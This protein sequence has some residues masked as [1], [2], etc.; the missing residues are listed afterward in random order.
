VTL[1]DPGSSEQ[2]QPPRPSSDP[3]AD[4]DAVQPDPVEQRSPVG[5]VAERAPVRDVGLRDG[6]RF[7]LWVFAAVWICWSVLGVIGVLI[8][9][10]RNPVSVPGLATSPLTTGWHNALTAGQRED[11]LWFQR[12][13]SHGYRS[14]DAS[15]AFFPL[16]PLTIRVVSMVPGVG[17][18]VAAALVAQASF[19]GALVVLYSLTA[20][21]LGV[22]VARRATV[23]LAVFPTAF[24]FLAA[25]SESLFL[26]L[27]LLAF[28]YARAGRWW[29]AVVPAVLVGLTRSVGVMVAAALL[30]EAVLQWRRSRRGL[31]PALAAAAAPL[32]GLGLY[33]TFWA[34][35]GDV[36]APV[37]AQD[38]WQRQVT[39]MPLTLL[40]AVQAAWR[41][42]SYWLIDLLVVGIIIGAVVG[43]LRLLPA[44]Y[45]T[46]AIGSLLLPLSE[47]FPPRPLMSMPR[48]VSVVFP[49]FWVIAVAVNRR[50]LP[51]SVVVGVFAG[52]YALLGLLFM[53]WQYIF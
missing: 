29:S 32:V 12:I 5:D 38:G 53:N 3:H 51:E 48:F 42:Q 39:L 45:L 36:M 13:A 40:H 26:L 18:A 35:H 9:S 17:V 1:P 46:Y 24:F 33:A 25:Y 22:D 4:P 15:A 31:L 34:V 47:P 7:A 28:W 23:Y 41:Y 20:R 30:V 52:G 27:T 21:E 8:V 44:S 49:A 11:A 37:K 6:V 10:A 16:Y 43:G 50:K 2:D 19:F 14:N